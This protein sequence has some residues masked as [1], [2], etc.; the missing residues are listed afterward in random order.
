MN[1]EPP[2]LLRG[3]QPGQLSTIPGGVIMENCVELLEEILTY[4]VETCTIL[5]EMIGIFILVFTALKCFYLWTKKGDDVRIELGQGIALALQFK[6][7]GEVLKT[8]IVREWKELG[9]LGA[10]ILLRGILTLIIHWEVESEKA[11]KREEEEELRRELE[12]KVL[13]KAAGVDALPEK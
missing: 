2:S 6:M 11:E 10:I 1:K 3:K 7:G 9:I 8:V 13:A 5:L 4:T 12:M